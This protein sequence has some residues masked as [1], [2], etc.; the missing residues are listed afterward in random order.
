MSRGYK[1][2]EIEGPSVTCGG[3]RFRSAL[4]GAWSVKP[5]RCGV[6]VGRV[7]IGAW[8]AVAGIR[9]QDNPVPR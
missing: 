8:R 3:C 6:G 4:T 1:T 7:E 5:G 2:L 9:F